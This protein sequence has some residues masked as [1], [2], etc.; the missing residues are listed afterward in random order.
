M[1]VCSRINQT[2]FDEQDGTKERI[3][4]V[5]A[6]LD[7]Q[8][9][10]NHRTSVVLH[11]SFEVFFAEVNHNVTAS[12]LKPGKNPCGEVRAPIRNEKTRQILGFSVFFLKGCSKWEPSKIRGCYSDSEAGLHMQKR[13]KTPSIHLSLFVFFFTQ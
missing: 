3:E 1:L 12:D 7:E 13:F 2:D 6:H 11:L 10:G 4:F 5:K 8:S 9:K